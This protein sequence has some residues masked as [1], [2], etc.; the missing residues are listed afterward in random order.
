MRYSKLFGKT[1][2]SAPADEVAKNAELLL[3]GGFIYK[4]MAGVY[5]YLPL[6]IRVIEKIKQ[7]IRE[8]MEAVGG[9][10]IIMTTLQRKELWEKTDRW[11]DENVDIWFKSALK[12]GSEVGLAWSHEEPITE[13]VKDYVSSYRDLPF[14]VFQFQNKL[15]NETRAKSGI[16]RTREFVMKDLYSY[17]RNAEEHDV[18]Y[19]KV[20]EAYHRIFDRVGLGKDTFFT[21]ASGGAF[22]K[23]SHEF[24]TVTAAGEDIIYVN[25]EKKLAVNKEVYTDE[26]LAQLGLTRDE[27]EEVAASEVGNIFSFGTAKCEE[28]GLTFTDE[29]GQVKPVTL[30]SY[31]IGIGRLM[32]VIVE[33]YADEK[34]IV[35]P[36]SVAPYQVHLVTVPSKDETVQAQIMEAAQSLEE[37]LGREGVEVLWDDREQKSP[38]EKFA[39]ADLLGMPL[40]LVISQ[41]TL[42]EGSVE[43]KERH[44]SEAKLVSL[45]EIKNHVETFVTEP[46]E[47]T[48][49]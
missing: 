21:F 9:Q 41:K 34:G 7:I 46:Y 22:T 39:D 31:G 12:N 16:M 38:G 24:Q 6:G 13:M 47:T 48:S 49:H 40:R 26:V 14:S 37:D 45:E 44:E 29:D 5:A 25:R 8:E 30:G 28:L 1:I 36:K 15:R 23:F 10:E 33:H 19:N 35:W 18:I 43:W 27:L 2:K 32:G 42:A 20:A 11:S 3:K 17:T 4:E